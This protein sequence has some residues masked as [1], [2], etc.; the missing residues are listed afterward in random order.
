MTAQANAKTSAY[1]ALM[2]PNRCPAFD[3]ARAALSTVDGKM[4]RCVQVKPVRF[5]M[6]DRADE[7]GPY[8]QC[9]STASTLPLF[10]LSGLA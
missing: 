4:V 1:A 9:S 2:R 8:A 6:G 7:Q 5:V 10:L 3:K